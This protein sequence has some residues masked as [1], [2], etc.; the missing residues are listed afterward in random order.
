[1]VRI[2]DRFFLDRRWTVKGLHTLGIFS[3]SLSGTVG[4][5]FALLNPVIEICGIYQPSSGKK[6]INRK[7]AAPYKAVCRAEAYLEPF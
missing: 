3:S 1:M 4:H 5:N 7:L 2:K 6:L